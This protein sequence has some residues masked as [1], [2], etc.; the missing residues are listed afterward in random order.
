MSVA[1]SL[2]RCT[3][4]HKPAE[5]MGRQSLEYGARLSRRLTM[6]AV[7]GLGTLDLALSVFYSALFLLVLVIS[8]RS[9]SRPKGR[10]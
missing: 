9:L 1:R 4:G 8:Y 2:P 10:S 7:P 5:R 6:A 3:K